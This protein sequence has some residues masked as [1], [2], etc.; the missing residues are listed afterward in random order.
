MGQ[1]YFSITLSP[2]GTVHLL[3]GVH[4][5][6]PDA[7]HLAFIRG[8]IT[9]L[10]HLGLSPTPDELPPDIS[11]WR[12]FSRLFF[13]H[14]CRLPELTNSDFAITIQVP[15]PHDELIAFAATP[16]PMMGA[17]YLN[18]DVLTKIWEQLQSVFQKE[19][20]GFLTSLPPDKENRVQAFFESYGSV[21]NLIGRVCFHLAENKNN[22][23][24][25][26]AFLA[27]ALE[28]D[29]ASCRRWIVLY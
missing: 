19:L 20:S 14:L 10:L 6:L 12:D 15:V 5:R 27:Q 28:V 4:A 25:P 16:P 17:E 18:A 21:W 7:I 23:V 2:Q 3:S 22:P 26:F 11:Y 13:S 1:E 24:A 8:D 29:C 9:G